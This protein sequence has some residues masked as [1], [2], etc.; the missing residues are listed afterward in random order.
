MD[1]A[2]LHHQAE[3]L[4]IANVWDAVS[5]RLAEQAGYAAIGTSSAAMAAMLGH[6]DGEQLGFAELRQLVAR[7]RTASRLPLSVDMEAGYGDSPERIAA[8]LSELAA[9]GVVGV[10][11]EDSL[12]RQG[13]RSLQDA[14]AFAAMLTAVR[15]ALRQ[16]GHT[17][18]L[19]VRTDPFLLGLSDAQAQTIARGRLYAAHGADGLFV[20]CVVQETDIRAIVEAV[21]L[22]LNV[23]CM[24]ALPDFA[25]LARLGV[26]RL[27]MGNAVHEQ[28]Q[29]SLLNMLHNIRAQQSFQAVFTHA[30]H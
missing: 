13:R 14:A 7:L 19:N 16:A 30:D 20:P 18:F 1:F 5:A 28:L 21:P 26:E 15:T 25:A 9:L 8:N 3:P 17:L 6:E 22:P 4:L 12:V 10:N 27:S 23:M 11:L 24:P 29:R 2:A